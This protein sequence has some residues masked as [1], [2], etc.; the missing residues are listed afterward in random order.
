MLDSVL[1]WVEKNK[2]RWLADLQAWLAIPSV[3]TQE[4]H[5]GD[6]RAAAEWVMYNLRTIGMKVELV[7]TNR[8]PCVIARTPASMCPKDAPHILIYGHYDVQPPE[9]L[10]LWTSGPFAG[11]VR[12]GRIF[13]RGASDDKGQVHCHLAA[14][15]A[16]KEINEGFPCNVTMIIEGEEEIGSP[17]LMSVVEKYRAELATAKTLII[18]DTNQFSADVP[19]ITYGL[20]GLAGMEIV[21]HGAK[22][23]LHSGMYGGAVA[24]PAHALCEMVAKLH[25]GKGRVTVP[26]FYD[27]VMELTARER[28][29]WAGLPFSEKEFAQTLGVE[30]LYG[31]AGYS[32]LERKWA[33]P[34]LEING[35]TSGYQGQGGKTV[36]PNRASA[37][38]TCRL[39]P[40]QNP[41]KIG[42]ALEAYLRTLV[43][44]GVRLEVLRGK[45]AG[46]PA[47]ITPLDSPAMTAAAVALEA[48]F[49]KKPVFH[50]EGGSIPVVAWFKEKLGV[51]SVLLGFGLP[52]DGIHAP[53][54][55][56][57]L[58][59]YYGGIK[60]AAVLYERLGERLK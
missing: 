29:M 23:D 30:A 26:G 48:G 27:D 4:N 28:E 2:K 9:P 8:H 54:E 17:N 18:S 58:A 57:D 34:T 53:N 6:V 35:L 59:C 7:E 31:E 38:I 11:E 24:N 52:E 3:S 1:V 41:E 46:S 13:A 60:T 56:L 15:T 42:D 16:W 25:D 19:S 22:T 39:V 44:V 14:L 40:N 45:G 47:A 37:K 50:R 20:R 10:E 21:L 43:P 36:L 5:A 55:K 33:R 49:G 12:E 51:D 32:A